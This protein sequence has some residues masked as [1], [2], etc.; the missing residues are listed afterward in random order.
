MSRGQICPKC[1]SNV[2]SWRIAFL[3]VRS[4]LRCAKCRARLQYAGA[5]VVQ[6]V[7]TILFFTFAIAVL[8]LLPQDTTSRFRTSVLIIFSGGFI[9]EFVI[10]Q[11]L[12]VAGRLVEKA[13]KAT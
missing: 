1:G 2:G 9:L 10:A 13:S 8:R 5:P 3:P 6:I 12:R 11:Y 7:A 4:A